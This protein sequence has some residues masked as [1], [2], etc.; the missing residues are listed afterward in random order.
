MTVLRTGTDATVLTLA[1]VA[2][3]AKPRLDPAVWDFI[4]GGAGEE[5]TLAANRAAFDHVWLR[6]TVLAASG[7]PRID[8]T[9]LGRRWAAPFGV[10]P[11]AYHTL[12]HPDGELATVRAA[13]AAGV[14]VIVST[15]AGRTFEELADAAA[16]PLWAQVYCFRDRAITQHLVE[17]AERV[18]FEALTVT[19]DAP[20]LGRRLRDERNGFRLPP[21]I[22]PANL[23]DG[24]YAS[25][26]AHA[27]AQLDPA[28]DWS[29]IGWLRSVS[30]LP[31]VVKGILT[32][33]D[34]LEAIKAG[35]DG[36]VVSNHGGRQLDGAPPTLDVLPEVAAAVAGRC[37]VLMDGG[38]RRGADVLASLA[39]GADSVLLGRPVLHG[40]AIGQQAGVA[41]VLEILRTELID[42][43]SLAGV[44]AADRAGPDLVMAAEPNRRRA[45]LYRADLHASLSDPVT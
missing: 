16:A 9:I 23:P 8:T 44:T 33:A 29:I 42:A 19:V 11:L 31:I 38:V 15:F 40:L 21:H 25:P 2:H 22:R 17:R 12:V 26:A 7:T 45:V 1:D 3:L 13:G 4:E 32:A 10:A 36:I 24:D 20:H 6:P 34:A 27:R 14:P 28:L 18:G 37:A 30:S 5:R 43:M 39:L 35:V 41:Q